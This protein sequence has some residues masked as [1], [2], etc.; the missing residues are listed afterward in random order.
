[1]VNGER[2]ILIEQFIKAR[3]LI[4]ISDS[5][6]SFTSRN[7]LENDYNTSTLRDSN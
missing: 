2:F 3:F 6:T 1:M 5:K 7:D 4:A